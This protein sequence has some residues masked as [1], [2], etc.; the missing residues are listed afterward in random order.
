M[1]KEYNRKVHI[2]SILHGY[3]TMVS[4]QLTTIV[5]YGTRIHPKRLV[6]FLDGENI[7]SLVASM[8][9][10]IG[11]IYVLLSPPCSLR[12]S[13][14]MFSHHLHVPLDWVQLLTNNLQTWFSLSLSWFQFFFF[15]N[16]MLQCFAFIFISNFF[17]FPCQ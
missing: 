11:F 17:F 5:S 4:T 2:A 6:S 1:G 10:Q 8:F 15:W 14:F 12:L 16:L 7:C 13:L 9:P 3:M